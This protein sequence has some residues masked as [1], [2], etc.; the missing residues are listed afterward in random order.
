MS[1][2]ELGQTIFNYNSEVRS[3]AYAEIEKRG[4]TASNILI[5]VIEQ[6]KKG[7]P[8]KYIDMYSTHEAISIL[9]KQKDKRAIPTLEEMTKSSEYGY[10]EDKGTTKVFYP[11][12]GFAKKLLKKYFGIESS[13]ETEKLVSPKKE[14]R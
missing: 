4:S 8:T 6:N 13:V 9:S 12:R 10:I 14:K 1:S 5:N 2:E 3:V 11:T 7:E